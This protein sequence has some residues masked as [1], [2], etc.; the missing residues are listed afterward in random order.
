MTSLV[1]IFLVTHSASSPSRSLCMFTNLI[2]IFSR[3]LRLSFR[4]LGLGKMP[5]L[6]SGR[7][8]GVRITWGEGGGG[9]A[10]HHILNAMPYPPTSKPA[11]ASTT[12][13]AVIREARG[14]RRSKAGRKRPNHQFNT[15][16]CH[17]LHAGDL[18]L[19]QRTTCTL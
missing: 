12:P 14:I 18:G 9:S 15:P 11:C 7:H 4:V 6:T 16:T 17:T 10:I 3:L 2:G 19:P 5:R 1:F 8:A 13:L